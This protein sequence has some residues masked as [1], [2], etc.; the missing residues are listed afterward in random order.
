MLA[1]LESDFVRDRATVPVRYAIYS[2]L[3]YHDRRILGTRWD[4]RGPWY[5]LDEKG[6]LVQKGRFSD[7]QESE[8]DRIERWLRSR[9]N[10]SHLGKDVLKRIW[11]EHRHDS[12]LYL[13]IV[14][15]AGREAERQFPGCEFHVLYWDLWP[16]GDVYAEALQKRGLRVHRVTE[17]IPGIKDDLPRYVLSNLDR[18]PNAESLDRVARYVVQ[19]V[20]RVASE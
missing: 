18:H 10:R 15:A 9:V 19:H 20:L 5:E 14:E 16:E 3:S 8:A 12:D 11:P 7:R 17:I 6:S 13:A 1:A 4:L 2:G